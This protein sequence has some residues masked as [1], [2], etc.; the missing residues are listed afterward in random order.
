MAFDAEEGAVPVV[1]HPV[2]TVAGFQG[3]ARL[4]SLAIPALRELVSST[5]LDSTAEVALFIALPDMEARGRVAGTAG[6][7]KLR[8]L[9]RVVEFSGVRVAPQARQAFPAGH[10]GF[11]LALGAA[12][13]LL[14][15]GRL[16]ACI[17]GGVDTLCDDLAVDAL[18][19]QE[20]L[21][22]DAN[23]V[24]LQPGEAAAFVLLESSDAVR[25]RKA[26]VLAHVAGI[27]TAED[28]RTKDDPPV[29]EGLAL[30]LRRL[31][32]ES[33]ALPPGETW[34]LSDRNGEAVRAN[35]WGYCQQRL[36]AG[37]PGLLPTS[38]WTIATSLGDTGA[39]SGALATAV[40]LRSFARAYAPGRCAVIVSSSDDRRRT[41]L[42][43]ERAG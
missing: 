33:G 36:T 43:L 25:R 34:F 37:M 15:Q 3:E 12:L 19:A 10:A 40:A 8:L 7:P 17:A 28:P 42:R 27:A 26:P 23:P 32:A 29:G 14:A 13:D 9:D 22:S 41:A 20:R 38:E 35:D 5:G 1:G 31:A 18:A 2:P 11:A 39:A 16:A 21:K 4:L 30:A 24:G 6:P